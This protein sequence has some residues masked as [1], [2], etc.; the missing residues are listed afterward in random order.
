MELDELNELL[1]LNELDLLYKLI[2]VA[3]SNKKDI[4]KV[5]RGEKTAGIRVRG[6]LQDVRILC[7]IIRDKIQIRKGAEWG[8]KRAPSLEKEIKK[9]QK[10]QIK[11]RELI[12]KRKK[13]RIARLLR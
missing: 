10:K 8:E 11:D 4:E 3:Q 1:E 7:E 13:E 5:L 2:D 12:E 9:A 6:K